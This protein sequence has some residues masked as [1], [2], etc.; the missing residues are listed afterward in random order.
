M[1]N[2]VAPITILMTAP[3]LEGLFDDGV[4][5]VFTITGI[6]LLPAPT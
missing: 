2:N 4:C 3:E 6:E 5:C 1:T